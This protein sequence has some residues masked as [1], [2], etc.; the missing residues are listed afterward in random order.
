[1]KRLAG[2]L[3]FWV[4]LAI[5]A[6]GTLGYFEPQAAVLLKP[7]GDGFIALVKMLISPVIFCTVVLGICGA[8]DMK[9]VGRVGG[10][11]LIYFEVVSTM[12]LLIAMIVMH[13][14][15]PG[16]GFNVD[17]ATLDAKAVAAYAKAASTQSTL[18]F[19]MHI[20]PTTFVDAF[21][22]AGSLL[23]V[24]FVAILFIGGIQLMALGVMGEYLG[25]VFNETKQRPL[26]FVQTHLAARSTERAAVR[27]EPPPAP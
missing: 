10:K 4:L 3:Y 20:I 27:D 9:K 19:V 21:T 22:G 14:I 2:Y 6:G 24:L 7:L 11:A 18:D 15:E 26:Y 13:L 8:G 23:Q 25:R 5:I 1:M 17:P 16:K 12:A